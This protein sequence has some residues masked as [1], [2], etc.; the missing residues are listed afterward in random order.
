LQ[1]VLSLREQI[2][3]GNLPEGH[4]LPPERELA[5]H[6]GVN[7]STV[8]RAYQELKADGF[9]DARVGRGTIVTNLEPENARDAERVEPIEWNSLFNA[10]PA[11]SGDIFSEMMST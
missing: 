1:I 7:R 4:P 6:L 3:T 9:L 8:V 5:R 11:S 2:L 10:A